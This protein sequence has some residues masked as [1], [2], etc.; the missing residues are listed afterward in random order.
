MNTSR[1]RGLALVPQQFPKEGALGAFVDDPMLTAVIGTLDE[2][3]WR[4]ILWTLALQNSFTEQQW[5]LKI[6]GFRFASIGFA[7]PETEEDAF[8]IM[9]YTQAWSQKGER[10]SFDLGGASFPVIVRP[11][12]E[13]F[14]GWPEVHPALGTAGCW[15]RS[16]KTGFSNQVAVLTAKHVVGEIPPG[17]SVN[18]THGVGKLLDLAPGSID[19]ALVV[20]P[21]SVTPNLE[22]PLETLRYVAQWTDV[23][24]TGM[25]SRKIIPTKVTEVW[26]RDI[27]HPGVPAR[28]FL[29]KGGSRGDSGA[30]VV[31][32][33]GRGVAIYMGFEVNTAT[34]RAEG[35]CQH[36]DQA[37]SLL[38]CDL[39]H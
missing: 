35:L 14:H 7:D 4:T 28:I 22:G 2:T 9:A 30:L 29:A 36:L 13:E 32:K 37:A 11:S 6:P 34:E 23:Q 10:R 19:A 15:A 38:E 24:F 25:G 39:Y 27:N 3:R 8:G 26:F 12:F 33:Q 5:G 20:P 17:T 31:D 1:S 21:A 16:R 18:T